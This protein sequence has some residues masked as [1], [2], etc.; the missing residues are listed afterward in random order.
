MAPQYLLF[1]VG[2][3]GSG[4]RVISSAVSGAVLVSTASFV[5]TGGDIHEYKNFWQWWREEVETTETRGEYLFAEPY[6]F[7]QVEEVWSFDDS[8]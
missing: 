2:V 8:K 5:R 1:L 3:F 6:E 7:R 4:T